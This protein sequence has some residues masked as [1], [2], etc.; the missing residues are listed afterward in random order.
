MIAML[1][2]GLLSSAAFA[3]LASSVVAAAT[4]NTPTL[5]SSDAPGGTTT[6]V[7]W[8]IPTGTTTLST[9][10]TTLSTVTTTSSTVISTSLRPRPTYQPCG[11]HR[12]KPKVCPRGQICIDDPYSQGCGL[13][14]DQS[15]ICVKPTFCGGIAGLVCKDGKG[16]PD[17]RLCVDDP[18]DD[19]D[20]KKGGADCGG[21]CV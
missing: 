8:G 3:V 10:T 6:C 21:I 5:T 16:K 20:P 15:G 9:D 11:G 17:G 14:C 13:A 4:T 12:V 7:S 18:R 1:V 19:C 2:P